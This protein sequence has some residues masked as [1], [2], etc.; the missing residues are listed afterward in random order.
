MTVVMFLMEVLL[1]AWLRR[2]QRDMAVW[3]LE[4]QNQIL[5]AFVILES[6]ALLMLFITVVLFVASPCI[7][8]LG[9]CITAHFQRA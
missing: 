6:A 5:Y 3:L 7:F 2:A 1:E 4:F 9:I 8:V